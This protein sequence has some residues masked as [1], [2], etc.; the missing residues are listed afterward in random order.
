MHVDPRNPVEVGDLVPRDVPEAHSQTACSHDLTRVGCT[1]GGGQYQ[2]A[3]DEGAAAETRAAVD[4]EE[5]LRRVLPL[6]G[7][8]SAHDPVA[9][10]AGRNWRG[11]EQPKGG[12]RRDQPMSLQVVTPPL[13]TRGKH[14]RGTGSRGQRG[15]RR[16]VSTTSNA[17]PRT[18]FNARNCSFD[19][20][21]SGAP[22]MYQSEPLSETIIP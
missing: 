22:V 14:V 6:G 4:L 18:R 21:G 8:R 19:Q 12:D 10:G 7:L 1:M 15:R 2:G 16:L 5:R 9:A 17:E 11:H 3:L 13:W 20:R